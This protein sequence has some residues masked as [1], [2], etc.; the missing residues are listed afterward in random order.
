ML[1]AELIQRR[2]LR[3]SQSP[4]DKVSRWSLDDTGIFFIERSNG[5][6]MY[7]TEQSYLLSSGLQYAP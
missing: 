1:E 5:K 4:K 3:Y 6:F 2:T 7:V